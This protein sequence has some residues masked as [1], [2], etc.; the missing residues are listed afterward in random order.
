MVLLHYPADLFDKEKS[1]EGHACECNKESDDAFGE[2]ET[3]LE[4]SSSVRIFEF[5]L[6]ENFVDETVVRAQLEENVA[7][8]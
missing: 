4:I 2:S 1:M 8:H 7:I 6:F 3:V 5:F